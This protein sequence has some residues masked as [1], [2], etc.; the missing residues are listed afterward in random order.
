MIFGSLK[1]WQQIWSTYW[2]WMLYCSKAYSTVSLPETYSLII[3]RSRQN[4]LI[5]SHYASVRKIIF[6]FHG[7]QV[8]FLAD[9]QLHDLRRTSRSHSQLL[10][11]WNYMV[12]ENIRNFQKGCLLTP[13]L[14]TLYFTFVNWD[15]P[16]K[17]SMEISQFPQLRTIA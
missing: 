15:G 5:S 3:A 1:L 9:L 2:V 13:C 16:R 11:A 8:I 12:S 14:E 17:V 4:H 7:W 6:G 10:N